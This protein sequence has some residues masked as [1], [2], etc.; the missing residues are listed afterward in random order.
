MTA[1]PACS[2]RP[3]TPDVLGGVIDAIELAA[4]AYGLSFEQFCAKIERF[5]HGTT[6]GLNALLTG[7]AARTA[8]LT[9]QGLRRHAGDRPAASARPPA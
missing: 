8:M 3:T 9:T 4:E 7:N 6:V 1:R 2:N 5:G